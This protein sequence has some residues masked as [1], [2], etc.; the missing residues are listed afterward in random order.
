MPNEV[1]KD[2]AIAGPSSSRKRTASGNLIEGINPL[3]FFSNVDTKMME[4]EVDE[5]LSGDDEDDV[6]TKGKILVL[7]SLGFKLF[8]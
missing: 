3:A 4:D 5:I 6:D 2:E 1:T 8:C 7:E